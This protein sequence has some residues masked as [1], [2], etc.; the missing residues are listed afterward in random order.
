MKG[1]RSWIGIIVVIGVCMAVNSTEPVR[2][3]RTNFLPSRVDEVASEAQEEEASSVWS[4]RTNAANAL[5]GNLIMVLTF[6]FLMIRVQ[7]GQ[8]M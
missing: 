7:V 6:A 4:S 5:R 3:G 8:M 2:D 1:M